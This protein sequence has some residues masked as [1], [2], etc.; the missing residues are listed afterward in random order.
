MR[1]S[2]CCV[3]PTFPSQ[4]YARSSH[5]SL[6][7]RCQTVVSRSHHQWRLRGFEIDLKLLFVLKA[8]FFFLPIENRILRLG[9]VKREVQP[10]PQDLQDSIFVAVPESLLFVMSPKNE[11]KPAGFHSQV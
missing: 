6:Q 7:C 11:K 10:T 8:S 9:D 3:T 5:T 2:L 1:R 4:N